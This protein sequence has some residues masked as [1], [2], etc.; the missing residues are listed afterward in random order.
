MQPGTQAGE[1]V[2]RPDPGLARGK[3]EA[4]S[5]AFLAVAVAAV[6]ITLLYVL[7][8]SGKLP[9][10]RRAAKSRDGSPGAAP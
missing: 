9:L 6:V 5:W 8:R 7:A 3:W 10:T 4:P 2:H 1:I